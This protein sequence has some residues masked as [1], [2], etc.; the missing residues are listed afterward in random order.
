MGFLSL[1]HITTRDSDD[2][3]VI[4]GV[5]NGTDNVIIAHPDGDSYRVAT[6]PLSNITFTQATHVKEE[7]SESPTGANPGELG[8]QPIEPEQITRQTRYNVRPEII[9]ALNDGKYDTDAELCEALNIS[10]KTF[11]RM[12][13]GSQ[14]AL[15][16]IVHIMAILGATNIWDV[17]EE[18]HKPLSAREKERR[19]QAPR[20]ITAKENAPRTSAGSLKSDERLLEKMRKQGIAPTPV[21]ESTPPF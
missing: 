1:R 8:H 9:E 4:L 14:P 7:A 3:G 18:K 10:P 19:E 11:Q 13:Q 2:E 17:I 15:H 16:T 6:E 5:V 12:K 21:D 20:V